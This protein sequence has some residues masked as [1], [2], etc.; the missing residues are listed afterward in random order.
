MFALFLNPG[1]RTY[2]KL[3][4]QPPNS[5]SWQNHSFTTFFLFPPLTFSKLPTTDLKTFFP[6]INFRLN[7][8]L[9]L[10]IFANVFYLLLRPKLFAFL[11]WLPFPKKTRE[12]IQKRNLTLKPLYHSLMVASSYLVWDLRKSMSSFDSLSLLPKQPIAI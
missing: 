10:A 6:A 7:G 11:I 4:S 5:P 2:R 8:T 3:S 12:R 9:L 1:K